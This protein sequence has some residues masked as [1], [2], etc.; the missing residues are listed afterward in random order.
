MQRELTLHNDVKQIELLTEFIEVLCEELGLDTMLTFNLNLV[1]EEAVTNVIMYAYPQ[2]EDHT[3]TLKTWTEQSDNV[4][5]FELKDQGKPFNPIEEAP[6]V[7]TTLSADE[8]QIGGLGIFLI[9][10]IMDEVTYRYEGGSNILT[11][12]KNINA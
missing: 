7:D 11:M 12:K 5:V 9:N 6:E 4:I 2:N 3:M 10:K 8:R 1:L